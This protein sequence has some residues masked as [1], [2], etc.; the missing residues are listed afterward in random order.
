M[1]E[2]IEQMKHLTLKT[3]PEKDQS[4]T[5]RLLYNVVQHLCEENKRLKKYIKH[6]ESLKNVTCAMPEWVC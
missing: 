2:I 3:V 1:D 4:L 5:P 6:L